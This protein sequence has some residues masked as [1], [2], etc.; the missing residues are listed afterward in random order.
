MK[1]SVT[2]SAAALAGATIRERQDNVA[3]AI[4][5]MLLTTMWFI[6][7]DSVTKQLLNEGMPLVEVVWGRFFFHAVIGIAAV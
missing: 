1:K 3:A 2:P 5:W 4:L 6:A 7:L